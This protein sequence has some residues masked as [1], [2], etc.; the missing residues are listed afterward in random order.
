V[1]PNPGTNLAYQVGIDR[2]DGSIAKF[3]SASAPMIYRGDRLPAELY[4]NAFVADP[5]A[6]FVSRFVITDDGSTLRASK[7]YPK[8]EFLAST[9]ERFRPVYISNAPDGTLYIVDM[10]RGIIQQR[11]DITEYLHD[12]IVKHKLDQGIGLGRIYRV[13]HDST[14]R[15][16]RPSL[17][18]AT[19]A[20]LVT[21]LESPNGWSRDTAQ[22]L[23][24]E[25]GA[26]AVVPALT[27][28]AETATD[29]RTR[30]HALWTLDGIDHITPATV[31]KALADPSRDVRMSALRISERFLADT[32]QT[33]V[34]TAV[35]AR[36]DDTDW[37]VRQQL[38]ASI[39]TLP[40]GPRENAAVTL[41]ERSAN[42]AVV[43][44]AALSGLRGSEAAVLDRLLQSG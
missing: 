42:N 10:Y 14:Q 35:L 34:Q 7:A 31:I 33:D 22:R 32:T 3:T 16:P 6:N 21:T 18:T 37:S 44:D 19:P 20:Q 28:E 2:E 11:A 30:L 36:L 8:G 12:H 9:D 26:T 15:G 23:L 24:V 25:R 5:A 40:E 43:L 29:P 38:A 39:G 13:M 17:S 4:G 1:R 27:R 41:L